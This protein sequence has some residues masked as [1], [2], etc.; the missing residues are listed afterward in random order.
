M[1]RVLVLGGTGFLGTHVVRA[2]VERGATVCV[3]HRGESEAELPDA[4]AHVHGEF[5]SFSDFVPELRAF[6]PQVILDVV[7]FHAKDGHGVTHFVGVADRAVVV[8]SGDVYRAFARLW[9][10]E[11]GPREAVPL[12]EDSALREQPSPDLA[13]EIDYDN[14][15]VERAVSRMGSLQTT[16]LRLPALFGPSDPFHRLFRYLKRMDD[17]RPAIILDERVA[18]WRFSRG[19]I[20]NVAAAVALA[21]MSQR[22]AGRTYNVGPLRADTEVQWVRQIAGAHGWSGQILVAASEMLPAHP[23]PQ[24]NTEQDLVLDSTRLRNELSYS[25]PVTLDDAL[26]DTIAWEGRNPP[27]EL[28]APNM[29]DYE[30]EDEMLAAKSEGL[31]PAE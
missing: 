9:G 22:A 20:V 6:S 10:S 14:I 5:A 1:T 18:G 3:F 8:T 19:Y 26:A 30:A 25:E 7:P 16:V 21:T 27:S 12:T 2:S 23:R 29:F 28:A 17:G 15:E 13:P 24:F 11:P 4:T 31:R